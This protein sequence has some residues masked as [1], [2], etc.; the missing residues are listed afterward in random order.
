[1]AV[2]VIQNRKLGLQICIRTPNAAS[3]QR[4]QEQR[5]KTTGLCIFQRSAQH[6]YGK[7]QPARIIG[8]NI[9]VVIAQPIGQLFL[10]HIHIGE[11]RE[12]IE[13][14]KAQRAPQ[15]RP[16]RAHAHALVAQQECRQQNAQNQQHGDE[17]RAVENTP[18]RAV[19]RANAEHREPC[20]EKRA[21]HQLHDI[22]KFLGAADAQQL[23]NARRHHLYH[24]HIG[25]AA[26]VEPVGA[27]HNAHVRGPAEERG[28]RG[29][30]KRGAPAQ[31]S[32]KALQPEE[33]HVLL[34]DEQ[35]VKADDGGRNKAQRE[36]HVLGKAGRR[37]GQ[38]RA[39]HQYG[40]FFS[41]R[42]IQHQPR[43]EQQA[44]GNVGIGVHIRRLHID[45][46]LIHGNHV[47]HQSKHRGGGYGNVPVPAAQHGNGGREYCKKQNVVRR[48][49]LP[50]HKY[51]AQ[52]LERI[53]QHDDARHKGAHAHLARVIGI[54]LILG[55]DDL[56]RDAP[57]AAL[58]PLVKN[59]P[60]HGKQHDNGQRRQQEI[61]HGGRKKL[62]P[63]DVL[64]LAPQPD[65]RGRR[66]A[67]PD[68][69]RRHQHMHAAQRAVP[70]HRAV[71]N[72]Q[73]RK[74]RGQ[75]HFCVEEQAQ[76]RERREGN[77]HFNKSD[78]TQGPPLKR[79]GAAAQ[80]HGPM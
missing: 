38:H 68:N 55:L 25:R 51:A 36:A 69:A 80:R 63:A 58:V 26:D 59:R 47:W 32:A 35:Q 72:K 7:H 34:L 4:Q 52:E 20:V 78:Q 29:A 15:R 53:I 60:A 75:T 12:D 54:Q 6:R 31:L 39:R 61:Y 79:Y 8:I 50:G 45:A 13:R 10:E 3:A 28:Q 5:A 56:G 37:N 76:R 11:T 73:R 21:F 43:A 77:G 41:R 67:K 70:D 22:G 18:Q 9:A 48:V 74:A 42:K 19:R 65:A 64:V 46:A 62:P 33:R 1:M 49:H 66:R 14:R 27:Q 2:R 24:A 40:C 23:G 71:Q 57:E 17:A 44:H 16:G 30:H